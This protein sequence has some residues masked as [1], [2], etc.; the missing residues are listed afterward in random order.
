MEQTSRQG[1]TVPVSTHQ[2][3]STV[4]PIELEKAWGSFKHLKLE[5]LV[6]QRVKSTTFTTGGPNQLD[7]IIK[8]EYVDGAKWELRVNEISDV[9]HTLG[10]Q[11]LSTEPAHQVTSI[12]GSIHLRAVTDDNT[13]FVTWSTDFS[14]DADA[15][16]IF[17]QKYKKLEFFADMKKNLS[18]GK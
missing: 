1:S 16:V 2:V 14:N 12:Q 15:T 4:L 7:S 3:E 10:Y 17:D 5:K 6:P 11:V 18:G 9:K 13:T 8:I